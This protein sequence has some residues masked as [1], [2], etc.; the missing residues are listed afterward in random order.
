MENLKLLEA[1][2]QAAVVILRKAQHIPRYRSNYREWLLRETSQLPGKLYEAVMTNQ[3]STVRKAD[4]ALA[5]LRF[6]VR[7]G[8]NSDYKAI[9][10]KASEEILTALLH[11]GN[12]IGDRINKM[13]GKGR[14][15]SAKQ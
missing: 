15:N 6:C 13:E 3:V 8:C 4:A 5:S 9:N 11:V 7:A 10:K 1:Y 2:E 12:L 14:H